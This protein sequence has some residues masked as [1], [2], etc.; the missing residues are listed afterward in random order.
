MKKILCLYAIIFLMTPLK[1]QAQIRTC[2]SFTNL[3][4][5]KQSNPKEYQNIINLESFIQSYILSAN[6]ENNLTRLIAPNSTITV[7]IVVHVLHRGEAIG[8]GRNIS[9]LQIQ[10]QID[11]L[12]QDFRRLNSDR[13]N[14]P[15]AFQSVAGDANFEFKL[16]CIDP[17]GNP[18]NGITRT[19]SSKDYF[20]PEN[21]G[22]TIDEV[23]TGIKFTSTGGKDAWP[24]NKYLNIWICNLDLLYGYAQRPDKYLTQPNT[25]GVVVNYTSFGTLGNIS[26][27]IHG[28]VCTHEIGH[29]LGV[30]HM[31]GDSECGD[32]FVDDTPPQET[33]H[34]GCPFFPSFN[35]CSANTPSNSVNGY[36][37][38][39]F[40]DNTNDACK[41]LFTK[42]QILRMRAV[43]AQGGPRASFIDNYLRVNEPTS[44]ICNTG[45]VTAYNPM[46]LPITWSV[47]SGPATI[48]SGQNTNIVTLQKTGDGIALVRAAS[49]GYFDDKNVLIGLQT[50]NNIVGL[51][52][53]IG[54]SPGE[55][56]E[57]EADVTNL[58]SYT[59]LTQ[60]GTILGSSNNYNVLI[61]VDQCPSNIYNGWLNVQLSYQNT[62]GTGNEYGE[63]TTIVCGTGGGGP[64][65]RISPIPAKNILKIE[66]IDSISKKVLSQ[67]SIRLIEI[68]DK[69]GIVFIKKEFTK[70]TLNGI[71]IP[72]ERLRNDVYTV[73]IFDGKLWKSIKII[74]QN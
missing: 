57:L 32:D 17:N 44:S 25:D 12:N 22:I 60:G 2:G 3:Q 50:P 66:Q 15:S 52:P 24:T 16:A 42:G 47:V 7:P 58:V 37:F 49:A 21:N 73:R 35:F 1:S 55:L 31:W 54:V 71:I 65:Y 13:I 14:T 34:G 20:Y 45:T 10:S 67:T 19:L 63:Y 69:M 68:V 26:P 23:A 51:N 27:D 72:V 53:P 38:M 18:T 4:L 8:A 62:C 61:Q 40:M 46:C 39:N 29:W 74:I 64:Q 9:D 6:N 36:M 28:R 5:L 56:L 30:L 33:A 70:G 59:W 43:F 41:N 11:V 48:I